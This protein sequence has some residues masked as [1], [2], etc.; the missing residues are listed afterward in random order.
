MTPENYFYFMLVLMLIIGLC[1]GS[2]MNVVIYRLP[3]IIY[4]QDDTSFSLAWPPSHCPSCHG[5]IHWYDLVPVVSWLLLRGKCRHCSVKISGVYPLSELVTGLWFA[6]VFF[7]FSYTQHQLSLSTEFYYSLLPS[8]LL[9]C[10]LYCICIT[11]AQH[12]LIPDI[13]SYSLLWS[14]LLFCVLRRIPVS[15]SEAIIGCIVIWLIMTLLQLM[16]RKIRKREGLGS[17]DI[18]LFAA[19]MPWVGMEKLPVLIITSAVIG[20]VVYAVI[21][22]YR[23]YH[24]ATETTADTDIDEAAYADIDKTCHFPFGPSIALAILILFYIRL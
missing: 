5:E 14:G 4:A 23:R 24:P 16:Y 9:F 2:F 17:G 1:I 6:G 20:G 3:R 7:I 12:Y 19:A 15:P 22:L 10:L 21:A 13:L 18:K 11:D 8:L